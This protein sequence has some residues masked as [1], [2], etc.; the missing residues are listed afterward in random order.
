MTLRHMKIFDAVCSC[1]TVT[2]A[3]KLLHLAQP[4]VSLAIH[5]ME[6]YY[7]VLLFDRISRRLYLTDAGKQMSSYCKQILS[8]IE[9]MEDRITDASRFGILRIGSSVTIGSKIMPS[10][11]QQFSTEHPDCR[12][13]VKVENSKQI[14]NLLL[15]NELDFGLIEGLVH[16]DQLIGRPFQED[17]LLLVC[18]KNHPLSRHPSITAE[19]LAQ[20]SLILREP[21]G[22]TRE[23]FD[24]ILFAL[25]IKINPLWESISTETIIQCIRAGIGVSALPRLLVEELIAQG[26]LI[27]LEIPGVDFRRKFNLVYHQDKHLSSYAQAFIELVFRS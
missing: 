5:E 14:E 9:E 25:G 27:H 2:G 20:Q 24:S 15:K 7:G 6:E 8:L 12:V 19:Q 17:E 26:E 3:A 16:S 10:L 22:G 1:G 13:E 23:L 11:I 21:G 4:S 18:G